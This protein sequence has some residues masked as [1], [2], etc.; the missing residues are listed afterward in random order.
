[1]RGSALSILVFGAYLALLS[2]IL[3]V[4]PNLLLALA[5]LP[6]TS[7]FWIRLGGC[8]WDHGILLRPGSA[9]GREVILQV[10]A[11]HPLVGS[12]HPGCFRCD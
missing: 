8:C 11:L 2:V 10:D 5:G 9:H 1:M 6:S 7:E 4:A 12:H 3:M